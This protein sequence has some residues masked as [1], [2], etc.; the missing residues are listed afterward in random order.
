MFSRSVS[1]PPGHRSGTQNAST[2]LK[3]GSNVSV[4]AQVA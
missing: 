3:Q 1:G 4:E 2:E